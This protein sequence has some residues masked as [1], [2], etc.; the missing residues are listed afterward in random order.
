MGVT[1]IEVINVSRRKRSPGSP[2]GRGPARFGIV[3]AGGPSGHRRAHGDC[4]RSKG[5]NVGGPPA[6]GR[7]EGCG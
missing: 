7:R 1:P 4:I 3:V 2:S 6:T 5:S